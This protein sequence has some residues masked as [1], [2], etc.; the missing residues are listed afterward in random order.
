M[1]QKTA[2]AARRVSEKEKLIRTIAL[3]IRP[4]TRE[5]FAPYGE[6]IGE[7]G[8]VEVDLDGGA[9]S[10]VAQTIEAHALSFD[11]MG[12][13]LRTEQVFAP[14]GSARSVIAVAPPSR[15]GDL[16]IKRL[17]AFL[18]DGSCAFKLH[19]GTWH[20]SAFPLDERATFIILD[21]EGTLED[22]FDLRDLK[23]A[24]GVVVEIRESV[25][26]P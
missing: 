24:H 2:A 20:T 10:V 14:L 13:H 23:T 7:R 25:S 8:A 3:T 1:S 15:D 6:L 18:I 21:R 26:E 11:F 19:R 12:R 9:A 4:M 17:G 16:D 22:D 5:T